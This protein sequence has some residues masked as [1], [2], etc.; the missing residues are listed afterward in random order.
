M[1]RL[2]IISTNEMC[3]LIVAIAK[4]ISSADANQRSMTEIT[5]QTMFVKD[6]MFMYTQVTLVANRQ[7]TSH[8]SLLA[9]QQSVVSD[10]VVIDQ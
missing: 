4:I 2:V 7:S 1:D 3:L 8:A 9:E 10:N 6:A 5:C